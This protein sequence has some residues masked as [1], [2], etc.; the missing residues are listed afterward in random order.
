MFLI[1][2]LLYEFTL[3]S[4]YTKE[5]REFPSQ[6]KWAWLSLALI[7]SN[8][9]LVERKMKQSHFRIYQDFSKGSPLQCGR[10]LWLGLGGS[11]LS[12]RINGLRQY[13]RCSIGISGTT[14]MPNRYI[15]STI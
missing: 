4:D 3:F 6:E 9:E 5:P 12:S 14:D 15:F 10:L 11:H 7:T 1:L 2:F 13:V 8:T